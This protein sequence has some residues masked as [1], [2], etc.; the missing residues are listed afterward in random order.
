VPNIDERP[1]PGV[2]VCHEFVLAGGRRIGVLTHRGGRRELLVYDE[3]DTDAARA[4]LTMEPEEAATLAQLL[5]APRLNE[6]LAAMQRIEGLAIDWLQAPA[7]WRP[8]TIAEAAIRSRTGASVVAVVRPEGAVPG[9]DPSEV[10]RP[11][12]TVIAVGSDD[13]VRNL[14]SLLRD[15]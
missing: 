14:R 4:V 7:T 6:Q 9:P 13:A 10:I 1:L 11:G 2:G 15:Q 5:G 3:G 12:D 8:R